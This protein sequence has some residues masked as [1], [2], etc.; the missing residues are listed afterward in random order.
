MNPRAFERMLIWLAVTAA[1]VVVFCFAI[2]LRIYH[3]SPVFFSLA[4]ALLSAFFFKKCVADFL[5]W[6]KIEPK[7][8]T[9]KSPGTLFSAFIFSAFVFFLLFFLGFVEKEKS[10]LKQHGRRVT[11]RILE[12]RYSFPYKGSNGERVKVRFLTIDGWQITVTKGVPRI[13]YDTL[14]V[15][16]KIELVYSEKI[17]EMVALFITEPNIKHY[18]DIKN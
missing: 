7:R 14:Q 13:Q 9:K 4:G 1:L 3:N 11:G 12:K 5:D 15:G 2:P 8:G 17:P 10:E 6:R 18:G 16:Q